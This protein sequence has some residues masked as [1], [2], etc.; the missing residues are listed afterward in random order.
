MAPQ[1]K[2]TQAVSFRQAP[3]PLTNDEFQQLVRETM[4]DF[5]RL[6][7]T[8]ILEEEVTALIGAAPYEQNPVR[9][10]HRNGSYT[11]DLVTSVG[12]IEDLRVPRTRRGF[13]TQVFERY[14]R[15]RREV[16]EGIGEMFVSGISTTGVGRVMENLTGARPSP[17]AVSRVFHKLEDEYEAWKT[18]T[19]ARHYVY[20]FADGTYFSVI[21]D[22]E[23][24]KMPIL[25]VIGIRSDGEREVLAF[26]VGDREN[27]PAWEQLLD[28]LKARGVEQVDLWI[29]DGN[30]AMLNAVE[31]KFPIAKRQRC[32]K[33]KMENVLGYI[34][35]KQRDA[36][37]PELKAIFYQEDRAHAEQAFAAFCAKY[38]KIYG[39]AVECLQRDQ[40]ALLT[41]YDFPRAHWK[42]IRTTNVIERLF[43]EVKK[44]SHK[45]SAAFRNEDSCLLMFYAV[46]RGMRFNRV[47]M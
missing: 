34:P 43:E 18:R 4:R 7:L 25:A 41:F 37:E 32:I 3:A 23:G 27:Q 42:T 31:A 44:R 1:A 15:R 40:G 46:I 28:E 10:D 13:R 6:A 19:L 20:C 39:T 38:A 2:D 8:T 45:M 30:R 14:Q 26:S 9:R 29:T 21:Y 35:Q 5:V 17:S 11:R 12:R 16:D 36:V 24:C 22:H 33:H 47:K